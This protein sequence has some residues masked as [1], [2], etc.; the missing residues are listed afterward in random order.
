MPLQQL[1]GE[2]EKIAWRHY[3]PDTSLNVEEMLDEMM[4]VISTL[5]E[6]KVK[7]CEEAKK[8]ILKTPY[9]K[10]PIQDGKDES[11]NAG[12]DEAIR[13]IKQ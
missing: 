10:T 2:L 7:M 4:P 8:E 5:L 3:S 6:K 9:F 13:I 12:L 1:R 11:F